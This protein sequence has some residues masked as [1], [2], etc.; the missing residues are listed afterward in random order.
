MSL[1]EIISDAIKYPF[2]DITNFL[3]VGVL[4]VLASLS[5]VISSFGVE[6]GIIAGLAIIIG[7]IFT[8][9]LSGYSIDVIKKG[10]ENSNDFPDIDLKEN[11][12][13]GI[14]ALIIGIVY[15]I[16][17]CIIAFALMVVFGVVGA[18]IDHVVG[19]LGI[20]SIIILIVF[21]LFGIFEM[22]ALAKF[23]DTKDL[24]A[25]LNIGGVL[26]DA[27]K[28]GILKII[29]F[30]IIVM[31]IALVATIIISLFAAIP[32]IGVII[33]TLI[34]GAFTVLFANKALGLLYADA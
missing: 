16:I 30:L 6:S 3:I 4:A 12:I 20:A 11:L 29:V 19:S 17:P 21:I 5:S 9:I 1:G 34:F 31:I 32:Y 7:F 14:K 23:A 26:E 27:K 15:M 22:V 18:G 28:I 24:G 25:A 8:L 10:I 2:S 13:N 33:A